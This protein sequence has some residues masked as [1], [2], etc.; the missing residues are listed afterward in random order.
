MNPEGLVWR[1]PFDA[2]VPAGRPFSLAGLRGLAGRTL[3]L[4]RTRGVGGVVPQLGVGR[5]DSVARAGMRL[6]QRLLE[7]SVDG[8]TAQILPPGANEVEGILAKRRAV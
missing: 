6:K 5:S 1:E 8:L 3:T 7:L 4:R 2:V